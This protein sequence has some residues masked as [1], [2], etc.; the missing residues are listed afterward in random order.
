M[1]HYNF[2]LKPVNQNHSNSIAKLSSFLI[3]Y[4]L[5]MIDFGG[6]TSATKNME[7][8]DPKRH[9]ETVKTLSRSPITTLQN[10]NQQSQENHIIVEEQAQRISTNMSAFE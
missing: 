9:N 1:Q 3:S 4:N 6:E 7:N 10:K 5:S 2:L 8:E